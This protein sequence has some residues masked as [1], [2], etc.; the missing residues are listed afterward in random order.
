MR[1]AGIA[2]TTLSLISKTWWFLSSQSEIHTRMRLLQTSI[3][4]TVSTTPKPNNKPSCQRR[5]RKLRGQSLASRR[6]TRRRFIKTRRNHSV[7]GSMAILPLSLNLTMIWIARRIRLSRRWAAARSLLLANWMTSESSS[8]IAV[9]KT[10]LQSRP[11]WRASI[12][13]V[14]PKAKTF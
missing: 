13:R 10:F 12:R 7:R 6:W 11:Q 2:E 14:Y 4:K 8:Q 3:G 5:K 9:K 1:L